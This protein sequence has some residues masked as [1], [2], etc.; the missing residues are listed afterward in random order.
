[1]FS[2]DIGT[3]KTHSLKRLLKGLENCGL[4]EQLVGL[5]E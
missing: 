4:T 2:A 1:M 3:E 5:G